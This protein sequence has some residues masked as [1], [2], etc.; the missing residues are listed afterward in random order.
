MINLSN[1]FLAPLTSSTASF[2]KIV[3]SGTGLGKTYSCILSLQKYI[4]HHCTGN[5][6]NILALFTAPQHNQISFP[7]SIVKKLEKLDTTI[8]KVKPISS[9]ALSNIN[10]DINAYYIVKTL[11][12]KTDGKTN[13]LFNSLTKAAKFVDNGSTSTQ[14]NSFEDTLKHITYEKKGIDN[15]L[16][17][18][19]KF[20]HIENLDTTDHDEQRYREEQQQNREEQQEKLEEKM[21]SL[22]QLLQ[23]F[24][25]NTYKNFYLYNK[26]EEVLSPKTLKEFRAITAT[27][28]PFLHYQISGESHALV[29]MTIAKLMTKHHVFTPKYHKKYNCL[30]WTVR[31]VSAEDLINDGSDFNINSREALLLSDDALNANDLQPN[32]RKL[33][34]AEIHI[35]LDESDSA[36][37][38]ITKSLH[39]NLDDTGIFQ[40]SGALAKEAGNVLYNAEHKSLIEL[41]PNN[42]LEAY[43]FLNVSAHSKQSRAA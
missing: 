10:A 35:Y 21:K 36:K 25:L 37:A 18:I 40:A 26:I 29:G 22:A 27:F 3:G 39:I 28:Y 20:S 5:Q 30:L 43:S 15:I 16:V 9:V 23:L 42:D 4:T 34:D 38:V 14:K 6:K 7:D 31:T 2:I 19:D 41:I 8:L 24:L 11:F 12:Y 33:F 1:I 17:N 32:C 13:T